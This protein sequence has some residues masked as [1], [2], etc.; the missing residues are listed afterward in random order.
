MVEVIFNYNGKETIIQCN[1]NDK[2]KGIINK[3]IIKTEKNNKN[4]YY[5]YN[6]DKINEKLA[7]N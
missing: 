2:M 7:F 4:I 1:I 6:G 5:L 3:Y